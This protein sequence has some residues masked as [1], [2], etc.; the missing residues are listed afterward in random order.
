MS[1]ADN[2]YHSSGLPDKL[3][4]PPNVAINNTS[5]IDM[6][7]VPVT[8][9]HASKDSFT[10]ICKDRATAVRNTLAS[11]PTSESSR[12]NQEPA[13][14]PKPRPRGRSGGCLRVRFARDDKKGKGKEKWTGDEGE[15]S[16][17]SG[18]IYRKNDNGN[19]HDENV[20]KRVHAYGPRISSTST[21]SSC[22][23]RAS[24]PR[25]RRSPDVAPVV[26]PKVAK[27]AFAICQ[28]MGGPEM[29]VRLEERLEQRYKQI[30][31]SRN[32][33]R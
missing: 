30:K 6:T 1:P 4:P 7:R 26:S 29:P 20:P 24:V 27:Y 18:L 11:K 3:V 28:S 31:E 15:Y 8:R 23:T 9:R 32:E 21:A 33:G 13:S 17:S 12:V 10:K 2:R 19:D 22:D 16:S 25:H 5:N 14:K